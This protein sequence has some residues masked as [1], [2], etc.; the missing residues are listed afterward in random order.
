[1]K[2]L[3]QNLQKQP[4]LAT[5]LAGEHDPHVMLAQEINLHSETFPFQ[6]THV[7]S[8]GYGTA[9]SSQGEVENIRLVESPYAEFGGIIR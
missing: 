8:I 9:I 2:I 6:A 7:S 1:M 4:G 5:M 3:I